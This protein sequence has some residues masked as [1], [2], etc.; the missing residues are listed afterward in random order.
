MTARALSGMRPTGELHLGHLCGV[1]ANWRRMQED[2]ECFFF[3][4]DWHALTT[5]YDAPADYTAA[6]REM[7][8]T[9]LAA[10][11]DSGRATLFI[12]S[13]VP[14]HAELHLLL[15]MLCPLPKL[16]QLPTYKE[17]K[18]NL[19]RDLDT[20]GF[21]GYPLLQSAD[22]LAY[23]PQ[24]VPVGEDQL[25]H[26]EFTREIARRFN[27]LY[28]GGSDFAKRMKG[29]VKKLP[30]AARACIEKSYRQYRQSGD[31]SAL[32]EALA[33]IDSLE[34][35]ARQRAELR[36]YCSYDAREILPLPDACLTP[37][38]KLPGT[39]GRKMS[40]SYDNTIALFDDA[41]QVEKKAARMQTDPARQRRTDKGNP[42]NC[43][44]WDLHK[45]FSDS[46]TRQW[47]DAGCRSAD[48]GCLDCKKSLAAGINAAL[49]PLRDRRQ[50]IEKN[51]MV[52]DIIAAGNRRARAV[53][54]DTLADVRRA[55]RLAACNP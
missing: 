10:G 13:Q 5:D 19:N 49:Q 14:E 6:A 17:Q 28:G 23:R 2:M 50:E 36:G 1:L 30:A 31:D 8:V 29:E 53:A 4:A 46:D 54:A 32:A 45:H 22:I 39:D 41:A 42:E 48:I 7:V 24:Q 34:L 11:I 20:Y 35:T 27:H 3:V 26:I 33:V 51:S 9:W 38:A 43:P 12:Q 40:K 44:V 25:P 15:S 47:A 18:E 37:A 52:D 55:M 16:M 21:L